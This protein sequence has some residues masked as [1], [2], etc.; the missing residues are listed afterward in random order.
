MEWIS[1]KDRFPEPGVEVFAYGRFN[2]QDYVL[3]DMYDNYTSD[4]HNLG[5]SVTHWMPITY[6]TPPE[7]DE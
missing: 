2:H 1:V 7:E 6:P 5:S 3:I 4:W